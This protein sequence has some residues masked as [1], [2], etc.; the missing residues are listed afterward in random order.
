MRATY[1]ILALLVSF[2]LAVSHTAKAQGVETTA[3]NQQV[4]ELA[5]QRRYSE[6]VP[7]AQ[8]VLAIREKALGPDHLDVAHALSNL[9]KLY[10][11]QGRY[12][13]AEPFYKRYLEIREKLL[14]P[15]HIDVAL[16]LNTLAILYWHQGRY[17]DAE[18]LYKRCLEIRE[19]LLGPDHIDVAYVL[20][21]LAI[22]YNDQGRYADA[23]P[24]Y[25]RSLEI[26]EK[27]LG[28]DHIE[29]ARALNNLAALYEARRRYADAEPLFKRSLEIREKLLGPDHID[30]TR[31]LNNLATV[32]EAVGRYTDAEPLYKRSL[33][34]S[35]KVLGP[36]HIDVAYALNNLADLYRDQARYADAEPLYKR[37]L[38]IKEKF[39]GPDHI[40][41]AH[42][43]NNLAILYQ[44]QSRYTDAEPLFQ[45]ALAVKEKILGHDHPDVASSLNNLALLY[46]QE[47]RYA[48]ALPL[49]RA[50]AQIGFPQETTYLTVLTGAVEQSLITNTD[51]FSE[52]Y[53]IIQ[54]ATSTAASK[55]INQLA[56]RFAADRYQLAQLVRKDQDLSLE[57]ERL[58]QLILEAASKEPS[59]RD[60]DKERQ[61]RDRLRSIASER[62][63]VQ[64]TLNQQFPDYVALAT[65]KPLSVQQT[66]QLL[67]DD[68]AFIVYDFGQQSYAEVFT[69]S[70]ARSFELKINA[71]DLKAKI[72]TLRSS[73]EFAPEF[74]VDASYRLYK[75]IFSPFADFISSKRRL[76]VVMNG[77]L[78]GFPLQLLVASQP[79]GKNLKDVDWL[80]REYTVTV[81]P[82]TAS[83]K[84]LRERN[85][86]TTAVK[87]MIGFGDPIFN[88]TVRAAIEQ[89]I[90][91][92]NRSLPEFYRG[93]IADT[94]SLAEALPSLP[95]T[96][97]E[98]RA[99]ARELGARSDDIKLG[100]AA[101]VWNV[102]HAP[103]DSY[104]V[105]Y[106][107]T[108]A[109]V[110]GEVEKFSQAKAE[111]ALVLSI[112]DKPTEKDDG[113]LRASDVAMLKLNADFV[114]LSACN[115]AAGDKPGAEALSGLARAFFYA[116][117]R[118]LIVSNWEV[119]SEST[120][121]LMTGVFDALKT[122]PH[123]S[124]AEA[125]RLSTLQMID[126]PS[127]PE[128][129]R[130]KYWAPFIVVGEPQKN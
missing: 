119:D 123:L 27:V 125:L 85:A 37:S 42:G 57:G 7:L 61:L 114:V 54:L 77:A 12:A 128:W 28:P 78:T 64:A 93:V 59:L 26:H 126:H 2:L 100:D 58:D 111:P 101:S 107:A 30:I 130:P 41:V 88:R 116:G 76:S 63:Q 33:E 56:V 43:L 51:A 109:L 53:Q 68:E 6:A 9:A 118:S 19:K 124:H 34:I 16:A 18:P 32:Y 40:D 66:Q 92:L 55:A 105:V 29:V 5:K 20:N 1:F 99:V 122:N 121:A 83:L 31:T 80:I 97:D 50:A 15:D 23:E 115:T 35:E 129:A 96:A 89:R 3:L 79:A 71:E 10:D 67:A 21:N 24:L 46:A 70:N 95:E 127:K 98:L 17:A 86:A 14:G 113:L 25:K 75:L 82:S 91:G 106:F 74:N 38:E 22:L 52:S 4:V 112:P 110:A 65:P 102:K 36:D 108:H 62:A 44:E 73:L 49:V 48:D 13:D 69:R 84:I 90:V 47:R 72:K 81:L 120:V 45:R 117:A 8:R 104:R 87:P 60:A 39:L 11:D 103:L 94:Q